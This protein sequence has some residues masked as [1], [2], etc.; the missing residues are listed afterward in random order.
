MSE[1]LELIIKII[2]LVLSI[3]T[4]LTIVNE[5]IRG[6]RIRI[7]RIEGTA[8]SIKKTRGEID[9]R[10]GEFTPEWVYALKFT[11]YA[12]NDGLRMAPQVRCMYAVDNERPKRSGTTAIKPCTNK[13]SIWAGQKA[14]PFIMEF[15]VQ[16]PLPPPTN[17][18]VHV[19]G[20]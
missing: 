13:E 19:I 2:G 20:F 6:S 17:L 8:K 9:P 1:T 16:G 5:F 15:Q 11:M 14:D 7:T 18:D 10:T 3:Y 4:I 12:Q